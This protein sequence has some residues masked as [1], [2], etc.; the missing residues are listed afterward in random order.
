MSQRLRLALRSDLVDH[1]AEAWVNLTDGLARITLSGRVD[2]D[3]AFAVRG[4]EPA[5]DLGGP[6]LRLADIG[7]A[8]SLEAPALT[9][10]VFPRDVVDDDF[11]LTL[12]IR[13]AGTLDGEGH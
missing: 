11:D 13:A 4:S 6:V 5:F 7:L 10:A 2:I 3:P 12:A 9:G 1:V 8:V